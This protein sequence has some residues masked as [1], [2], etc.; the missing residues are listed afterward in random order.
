MFSESMDFFNSKKEDRP[1][2]ENEVEK[3]GG[4][5]VGMC[6]SASQKLVCASES[7]QWL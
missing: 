4:G 1:D 6:G 3:L 2:T 7:P 5:G